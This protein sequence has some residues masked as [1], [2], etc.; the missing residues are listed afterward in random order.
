MLIVGLSCF[1]R[2]I[3]LSIQCRDMIAERYIPMSPTAK[4]KLE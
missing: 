4:K 2:V 3:H 1:M